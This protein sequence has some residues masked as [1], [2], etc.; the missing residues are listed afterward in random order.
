MTLG[1]LLTSLCVTILTV[2][3]TLFLT[4]GTKYWDSG[5]YDYTKDHEYAK[6]HR[7]V[8]LRIIKMVSFF[9]P[10]EFSPNKKSNK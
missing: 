9:S 7:H 4:V 3:V 6:N 8:H 10:G 5:D 2:T 1:D